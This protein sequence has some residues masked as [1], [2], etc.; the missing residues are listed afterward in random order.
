MT[1]RILAA[2]PILAII[3]NGSLFAQEPVRADVGD[4]S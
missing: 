2:W 1:M 4:P 3:G